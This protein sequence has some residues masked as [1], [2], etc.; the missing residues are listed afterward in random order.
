LPDRNAIQKNLHNFIA[1]YHFCSPSQVE[2]AEDRYALKRVLPLAAV[3]IDPD[4]V[5]EFLLAFWTGAAPAA[6]PHAAHRRM[7][8]VIHRR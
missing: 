2:I 7:N 5:L 1:V 6:V 3:R 8:F 4:E